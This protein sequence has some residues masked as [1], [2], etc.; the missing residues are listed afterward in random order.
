MKTKRKETKRSEEKK[1]MPGVELRI[2]E[3][4][5]KSL[6]DKKRKSSINFLTFLKCLYRC[7]RCCYHYCQRD[8]PQNRAEWHWDCLQSFCTAWH[9]PLLIQLFWERLLEKSAK[10]HATIPRGTVGFLN[11]QFCLQYFRKLWENGSWRHGRVF[12]GPS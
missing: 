12:V 10:V 6:Q 1:V 2:F 3:V 11:S 7:A 4:N 8:K 9:C 5:C